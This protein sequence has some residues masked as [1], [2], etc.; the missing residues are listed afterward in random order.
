MQQRTWESIETEGI[1]V[2]PVPPN[3]SAWTAIRQSVCAF[4]NTRG[5]TLV[6]GVKDVQTPQ[7]HFEFAPYSEQ[8]SGNASNLRTCFSDAQGSSLDY[9][10][11][12]LRLE[13]RP[14]LGGQVLV[15]SVRPLP[16][17]KKFCFLDRVA[18]ERILDRDERIKQPAVEAQEERRREMETS[19]EL[20]PVDGIALDDLSL[21]RINELVLLINQ[22]QSS[23][24]ETIK[25]TLADAV[26]FLVRRRF[27][28]PDGSVTT[29]GALVCATR[30][31]ERLEFRSHLDVF[32][33]VPNL[34]AQDKKTFRDNILQL[35][36]AGHAWTLRNILT[37]VSTEAGGTLVAEYPE[38][39][40]R[41]SINNALAHRDYALNRPVQLTI[42]PRISLTIRNPGQLPHDLILEATS[43]AVPVRRIFANPRARNPRLADV[44][45]L[46]NKWEGKGIGMSE[47]VNFALAN[48]ID[49][50]YY[51]FNSADDLSLVIPSG[52]VLDE[53]TKAWF[54]LMDGLIQRKSGAASLTEEQATVLA[55]L[56]KC[57]RLDRRGCYTL[58]L[59]PSNNHFQ[60]IDG[61]VRS[62]LIERHPRSDR[63]HEV[64]VVCREL[65]VEDAFAELRTAF[66]AD[67]EALDA[68]GRETLS[69]I[70]LAQKHA[71]AGGLNAKQ[72]SRLLRHRLPAEATERGDDEF[73]RAVRYRVERNAP[74][75]KSVDLSSASWHAVP[76]KM[77]SIKGPSNRPLF[78]LNP[79]Y[80]Q[81]LFSNPRG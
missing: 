52:Q 75:K 77:L 56:L 38:K 67:F 17:D 22:G 20:R 41:E 8:Q 3:A 29:L 18:Y 37:G 46:H 63:Y 57:E 62:T 43:D 58:A 7:R 13:A 36:E 5:G 68:I 45:K 74:D 1:E 47:L 54:G 23:P 30:P 35:M 39:L 66:G 21:Q 70:A 64:Y 40:I 10:G 16:E 25:S 6:L 42:R 73:Y 80:Q 51:L 32:V 76:D 26:P 24:I 34:V 48:K 79:D 12:Y 27:M 15:V 4:L 33:D 44:L 2:K 14:F 60:V 55:Y 81:G 28:L 50:P 19:R 49:A 59:T 11:E 65:A 78:R 71:L 69:M 61:L 31:E 53:G 9:I 72:V